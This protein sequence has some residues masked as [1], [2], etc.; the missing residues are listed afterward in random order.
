M[1]IKEQPQQYC[2][3][4]RRS[5]KATSL[6]WDSLDALPALRPAHPQ[7]HRINLGDRLHRLASGVGTH[8]LPNTLLRPHRQP[9]NPWY[10]S[11]MAGP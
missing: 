11:L 1:E 10:A 8:Q 7:R 6:S 9:G 3:Q 2:G 4:A 5:I